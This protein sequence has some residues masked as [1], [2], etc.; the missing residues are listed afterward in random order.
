MQ[1]LNQEPI[2]IR[3]V[4]QEPISIILPD[5]QLI[6][7]TSERFELVQTISIMTG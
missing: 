7:I 3:T 1:W 5:I 2:S 4:R 6:T